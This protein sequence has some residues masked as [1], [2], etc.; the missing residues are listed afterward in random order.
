[1]E[2]S[3]EGILVAQVSTSPKILSWCLIVERNDA[4]GDFDGK[5]FRV[6]LRQ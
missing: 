6:F 4:L 3:Q 1:M 5:I 2:G